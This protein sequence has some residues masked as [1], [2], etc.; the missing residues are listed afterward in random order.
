MHLAQAH[1]AIEQ[2]PQLPSEGGIADLVPLRQAPVDLDH[3][4]LGAGF[5]CSAHWDIGYAATAAPGS[6]PVASD[7]SEDVA[8]WPVDALPENVPPGF[9][10]R[11]AGVLRELAAT[12]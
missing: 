4:G 11:L 8:W 10:A 9:A 3:H 12:D 7:E 2:W 6:T 5:R 1:L